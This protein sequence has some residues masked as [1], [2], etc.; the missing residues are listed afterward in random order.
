MRTMN[1]ITMEGYVQRLLGSFS[2]WKKEYAEVK[3]GEFRYYKD[4][5]KKLRGIIPLSDAKIEMAATDPLRVAIKLPNEQTIHLKCKDIANKVDWVNA[6]SVNEQDSEQE[7]SQKKELLECANSEDS[8][9]VRSGLAALFRAKMLTNTAKLDAFVTQV[10]TLQ[11]LLEGTL[12]DFSADLDSIPSPT[13]SLKENADNI[14][15]YTSELK[16][17]TEFN[18]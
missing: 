16:V 14:K 6:L 3:N 7:S 4:K 17:R 1:G 10:W 18:G 12:S 5:G 2:G 13:Q 8:R 11:G 15:R 9:G